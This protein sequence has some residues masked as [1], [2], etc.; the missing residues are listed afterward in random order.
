MNN[1]SQHIEGCDC[2]SLAV[3]LALVLAWSAYTHVLDL[4]MPHWIPLTPGNCCCVI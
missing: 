2:L 4:R 3:F 1:G